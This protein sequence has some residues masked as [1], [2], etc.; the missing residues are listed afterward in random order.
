MRNGSFRI[1]LVSC[2]LLLLWLLPATA[3]S[4]ACCTSATLSGVGRLKAWEESAVGVATSWAHSI[5]NWNARGEWNSFGDTYRE[6]LWRSNF[7]GIARVRDDLEFSFALPWVRTS[8]AIPQQSATGNGLGH[9]QVGLRYE[10]LAIGQY[11]GIPG[12]A[13]LMGVT[14]PT[15]N[16]PDEATSNP[17]RASTTARGEW[18]TS[19]AI[20]MEYAYLPWFVKLDAGM[21]YYPA[22]THAEHGSQYQLAPLWQVA[23]SGGLELLEDT[24]VLGLS[25]AVESQQESHLAQ[26]EQQ[27]SAIFSCLPSATLSWQADPHWALVSTVS[28][29]I[30][31]DGFGKNTNDAVTVSLGARYGYF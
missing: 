12:L 1:S 10:A 31:V 14:I 6:S 28:S 29:G 9:S 30:A 19:I 18:A 13:I 5:G 15:G 16:R 24:L 7:W 20:S 25:L 2:T 22:Y 17:L 8:R 11:R 21:R 27:N 26:Q 3:Q 23:L 4:A